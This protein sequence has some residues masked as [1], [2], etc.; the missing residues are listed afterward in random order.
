[1]KAT[2]HLADSRGQADYGWLQTRYTFSFANY[3]NPERVHF[4][5]LR[6]LN[7][8]VIAGGQGF[9]RHPHDNMEI[10][11]IP[12]EGEIIHK[13]SMGNTFVLKK[14]DVQTMSAGTGIFH[15][16]HNNR[17]DTTLRLLQIWVYPQNYQ[18]PP[19]YDQLTFN[20]ADRLNTWQR[21]VS[22]TEPEAVQIR[23]QAYFSRTNLQS[24]KVLTYALHQKEHGVYIFLIEGSIKIEDLILN[25]RD[26]VG[27]EETDSVT[28]EARSDCDILLIEVPMLI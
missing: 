11:T 26:G 14:N 4:G 15:S 22:C 12:L 25:R 17:K 6:V 8:D 24:G 7:D 20:P 28:I 2:V 5:A 3:H 27:L 9:D 13:D 16:E 21:L 23:Q 19:R 1:M 18:L 10:I